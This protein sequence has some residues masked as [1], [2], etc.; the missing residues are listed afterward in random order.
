[1]HTPQLDRAGILDQ[2]EEVT[3]KHRS[4]LEYFAA[5]YV[6]ENREEIEDLN[7]SVASI[8]FD[9]TWSE[10]AFYYVGLRREISQDLLERICSYDGSTPT[11]VVEKFL[12]GRLLQAGWHSPY[13]RHVFGIKNAILCAPRVRDIF[14]EVIDSADSNIPGIFSDFFVLTLADFSFGSAF[15]ERQSRSILRKLIESK[16]YDDI[17]MAVSLFSSI[18]RFLD[19]DERKEFTTDLLGGSAALPLNEQASASWR[20]LL[21]ISLIAM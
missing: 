4:F 6:Y 15:L 14:R 2:R 16:S 10:V 12:S 1:M 3:F 17:Y 13:Q 20:K 18:Y 5:F 11:G 9:S 7:R 8:Y 21:P 19:G